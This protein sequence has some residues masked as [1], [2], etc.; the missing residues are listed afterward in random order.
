[1]IAA[2]HSMRTDAGG[3]IFAGVLGF[4]WG[5]AL[6]LIARKPSPDD[7]EAAAGV[8]RGL[9]RVGPHIQWVAIALM[10]GG[11]SWLVATYI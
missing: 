6:R 1:M 9:R 11:I 2:T 4:V 5:S 7:D 8:K 10:V 3:L